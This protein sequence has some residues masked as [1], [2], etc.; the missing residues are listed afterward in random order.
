MRGFLCIDKSPGRTSRDA[1]NVV[2]RLIRPVK[3]GHAGTLDPMA[4]GVLVLAVGSATKLISY[5]QRMPKS[6][7]ASF[8]LGKRSDTEDITGKV[9]VVNVSRTPTLAEV[10]EAA[11]E[12]IGEIMQLPPKF[13]ALRVNGKRAHALARAGEEVELKPR[14][15][16]IHR[17]RVTHYDFPELQMDVECGSGTYIR[18]LG[19]DIGD[20]LGCGAAMSAL[21]R[22]QIGGFCLDESVETKR[23]LTPEDVAQRLAPIGCGV[24]LP[25]HHLTAVQQDHVAFG[26]TFECKAASE[27]EFAALDDSGELIAV[28]KQVEGPWYKSTVNFVAK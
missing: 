2:Q 17:I 23:L 12:F 4:T 20:R 5:V 7:S 13:S 26:R 9:E 11:A 14:P 22:T 27:L 8:E 18:S 21:R 3:V 24:D 6:Y 15:I 1:V 19:R 25:T 16:R 10:E 28:M